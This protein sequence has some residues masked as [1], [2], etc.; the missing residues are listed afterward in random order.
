[1][2]QRVVG[3]GVA[4]FIALSSIAQ[5]L[6]QSGD[7]INLHFERIGLAEGLSQKSGNSIV[8]DNRGEGEPQVRNMIFNHV[9][10]AIFSPQSTGYNNKENEPVNPVQFIEFAKRIPQSGG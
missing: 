2:F 10:S 8:Q 3:P 1:M 5:A 9:A 4:F 6:A 7:G